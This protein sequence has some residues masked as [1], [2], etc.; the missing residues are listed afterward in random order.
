L[1]LAR[2]DWDCGVKEGLA[3]LPESRRKPLEPRRQRSEL[4]T[5]NRCPLPGAKLLGKN[6]F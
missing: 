5:G 6:S 3:K 1:P 4:S 2:Q